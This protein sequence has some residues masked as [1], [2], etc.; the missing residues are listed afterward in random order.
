M[1]ETPEDPDR[2]S[3][4]RVR[5][6]M[7]MNPPDLDEAEYD[8]LTLLDPE[9]DYDHRGRLMSHGM[10]RSSLNDRPMLLFIIDC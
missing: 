3:R 9:Y 1:E 7:L 10:V 8:G 5:S 4:H 6:P 2:S